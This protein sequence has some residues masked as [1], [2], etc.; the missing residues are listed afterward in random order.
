[1]TALRLLF[2]PPASG[3]WN[4]AVDEALLESAAAGLATLR[5]YQWNE[6]TLSLGYFQCAADREQ[7][8]P[9]RKC[10]LV[11]RASGG[12]AIVHDCELTYSIAL[13]MGDSRTTAATSLYNTCHESLVQALAHF[14]VQA[15]LHRPAC[16]ADRSGRDDRPP[17]QPFLCFA[18]RTCGDIVCQNFKIVGSAQRR[19]RGAVLQHGSILLS[20]SLRAPEL[21]GIAQLVGVQITADDLAQAWSSSLAIRLG[22]S[23]QGGGLSER[24]N[25]A[26]KQCQGHFADPH[27]TNRR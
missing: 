18:R 3:T 25:E 23:T 20:E 6:P 15:A 13:P 8:A 24:E 26:A 5:F 9:S 14:G 12:G 7:H 1:M 2:D 17:A 4:M 19:R 21:P 10:P 16:D 22:A 11:R 27:Y